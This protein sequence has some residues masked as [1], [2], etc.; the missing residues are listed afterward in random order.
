MIF[1]IFKQKVCVICCRLFWSQQTPFPSA[2]MPV[3]S[4][5]PDSIHPHSLNKADY[6]TAV[7]HS[8]V[9]DQVK[10]Q[11]QDHFVHPSARSSRR[12]PTDHSDDGSNPSLYHHKYH[13]MGG[14]G[15]GGAGSGGENLQA[16]THHRTLGERVSRG[17]NTTGIY[18]TTVETPE[19][20]LKKV[21]FLKFYSN[22]INI[23]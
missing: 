11:G 21:R 2:S 12:R 4:V 15:R 17:N 5:I 9:K 3:C 7:G 16:S 18:R 10:V 14:G 19:Q 13:V 22:S 1:K 20:L 8:D 6:S 23:Y